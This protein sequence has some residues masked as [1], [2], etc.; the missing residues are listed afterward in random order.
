MTISLISSKADKN[1]ECIMHSQS[2]NIETMI[3]MVYQMK[4]LKNI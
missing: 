1:E 2:N 4:L 3:K